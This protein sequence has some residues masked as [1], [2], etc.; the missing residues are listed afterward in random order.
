MPVLKRQLGSSWTDQ[1]PILPAQL[2]VDST[3]YD[4]YDTSMGNLFGFLGSL[5]RLLIFV[6]I[7]Q[8]GTTLATKFFR[9]TIGPAQ[10]EIDSYPYDTSMEEIFGVWYFLIITVSFVYS[11]ITGS[12]DVR[13]MLLLISL[14]LV[15][16]AFDMIVCMMLGTQSIGFTLEML[17]I[18]LRKTL[19]LLRTKLLYKCYLASL[20]WA[21]QVPRRILR[22]FRHQDGGIL[23]RL[24]PELRLEVNSHLLPSKQPSSVSRSLRQTCRQ[25]NCELE[26]EMRKE[27]ERQIDAP[28]KECEHFILRCDSSK[29]HVDVVHEFFRMHDHEQWWGHVNTMRGLWPD[30]NGSLILSFLDGLPTTTRSVGVTIELPPITP[31]LHPAN[32]FVEFKAELNL[33]FRRMWDSARAGE[34]QLRS[35]SVVLER[36]IFVYPELHLPYPYFQGIPH[37]YGIW[38]LK[39]MKLAGIAA[40]YDKVEPGRVRSVY[41]LQK[42]QQFLLLKQAVFALLPYLTHIEYEFLREE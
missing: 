23:L 15:L 18:F 17:F 27:F 8:L 28:Q 24:P 36:P 42:D 37:H 3:L 41:L 35:F 14:L 4:T 9:I 26:Y 34:A 7:R 30:Y 11:M 6:I 19:G 40:E 31:N 29:Y 33:Y 20:H 21:R 16:P 38:K 1:H 13:Y 12:R 5:F 2:T 10:P 22:R 39:W 25:I 32:L